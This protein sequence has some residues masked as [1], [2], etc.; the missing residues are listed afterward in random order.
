MLYLAS[1]SPRR[2]DILRQMKISFKVAKSVYHEKKISGVEPFEIA[3]QHAEGK[4][5]LAVIPKKARWILGADTIVCLGKKVFGKPRSD[6]EAK[7]MLAR[8]SGKSHEVISALALR[9]QK[10]QVCYSAFAVTRVWIKKLSKK[11]I[12]DYLI[13]IH[14][15]DKAG[16]YAIQCRPKIVKK[17]H[18]SY[19]NVVGFPRE[20]FR[21]MLSQACF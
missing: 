2:R 5:A 19:S 16:S 4:A 12:E 14:V 6:K 10:L 7:S 8:L 17:I 9:D 15:H 1:Q 11:Q 20:L 18:G 21:K 13:R 3:L